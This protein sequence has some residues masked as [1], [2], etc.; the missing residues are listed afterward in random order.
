MKKICILFLILSI[1]V[2]FIP[3]LG[4]RVL[5]PLD[6]YKFY[7]PWSSEATDTEVHN[8]FACDFTEV[9]FPDRLFA[10]KSFQRE[11]RIGWSDLNFSG[12]AQYANTMN[13]YF[14]WTTQLN[15][16][17]PFWTAWHL[18]LLGQLLLATL[19]MAVFL[20]SR[21]CSSETAT[22]GALCYGLNSFF[23][24]WMF[25][26]WMLGAFCWLP[27]V[28]WSLYGLRERKRYGLLSPIFLS[29]G[30][31][32]GHLQF[33]AYYVIIVL[34]LCGLWVWEDRKKPLK[35]QLHIVLLLASCG[36]LSIGMTAFMFL[37]C[38]HSYFLTFKAGLVRGAIGYP[39][40]L[41]QPI[42]TLLLY[43]FYIFPYALGSPQGLDL[44]KLFPSNLL[45]VPFVGSFT[46]ILAIYLTWNAISR[47]MMINAYA[48]MMLMI[49]GLFLP[50][51]PLVGPLYLRLHILFI[52]GASWAAAYALE[53]K[54]I[55]T[56]KRLASTLIKLFLLFT[57]FWLIISIGINIFRSDILEFVIA[58]TE[59]RMFNHRFGMFSDWWQRRFE[60]AVTN[61]Q[62][63]SI[64]ML[65][66]WA[67]LG[68]ILIF[69][70]SH[71]YG[72]VSRKLFM[73]III[74]AT[75]GQLVW[76]NK[77]WLTYEN[78]PP[79]TIPGF[80]GQSMLMS[81]LKPW[82]R[83]AT[84]QQKDRPVLFPLNTLSLYNIAHY[85]GY[86]SIV[87]RGLYQQLRMYPTASDLDAIKYGQWGVTH[88][89]GYAD[90]DGLGQDWQLIKKE[91][92]IS[93]FTNLLAKA[94]YQA[95]LE[96]GTTQPLY[97]E[98]HSWN[99]RRL[100]LPNRVSK[101]NILENWGE[102]WKFRVNENPWT[103]M[104][105]TVGNS[106]YAVL[107]NPS[108]SGDRFELCYRPPKL[109]IGLKISLFFIC[110]YFLISCIYA[111]NEHYLNFQGQHQ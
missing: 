6:I 79:N 68:T 99:Y 55:I 15:R 40:G 108:K 86:G 61:L 13:L 53:E 85:H 94:R 105:K 4:G 19:G 10:N 75:F 67:F 104:D 110:I 24:T 31:L 48:P 97:P 69:F 34:G 64:E 26:C 93:L 9:F 109:G 72:R 37:P 29:L 82:H 65:V 106:M 59:T 63:W 43:P 52:F 16:F 62:L 7:G 49:L 42:K 58:K 38:I 27:W 91:G 102:G 88:A 11:G 51:T 84:V 3:V 14:D 25:H 96:Q 80:S 100:S 95:V 30:F 44:A 103:D 73:W 92:S 74:L 21:K 1:A 78:V 2:I 36:I 60:R 5:A 32:G 45:I 57:L 46:T 28:V 83:V 101:I 8:H 76:Y 22:V 23:F 89:I 111:I 18:G 20:R 66:P 107:A 50:L 71:T 56:N 98:V 17:L 39:Q 35:T 87:P 47:K 90:E 33:A 54:Q 41:T 70:K 77:N 81:Y 12:T